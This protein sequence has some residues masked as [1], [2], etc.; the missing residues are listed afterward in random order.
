MN[1]NRRSLSGRIGPATKTTTPNRNLLFASSQN[2]QRLF[3]VSV[4]QL[5]KAGSS[6]RSDDI[7]AM[8]II[9]SL[10]D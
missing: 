1:V 4:L 8:S 7:T 2:F 5:E 9:W 3:Y 10:F 6:L